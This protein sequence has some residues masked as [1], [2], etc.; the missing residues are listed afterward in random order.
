MQEK[1]YCKHREFDL[2]EGCPQ[3]IAERRQV[4]IRPEQD[5]MEDGLRGE[6]LTLAEGEAEEEALVEEEHELIGARQQEDACPRNGSWSLLR[7][8]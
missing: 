8:H 5:E 3:C 1:G 6:G 7:V 4:G 2:M